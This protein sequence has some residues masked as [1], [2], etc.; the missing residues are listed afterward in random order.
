MLARS[1]VDDDRVFDFYYGGRTSEDLSFR[2]EFEPL[3]TA[4]GGELVYVTEDG[5]LGDRG[6]VTEP[7]ERALREQRY[8]E[9]G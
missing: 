9:A 5:S 6:L 3:A 1:L 8:K 7:L 4:S 2:E